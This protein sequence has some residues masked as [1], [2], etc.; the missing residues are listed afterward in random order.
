MHKYNISLS[1][2][3]CFIDIPNPISLFIP[4]N[5]SLTFQSPVYQV[6]N[7]LGVQIL[8]IT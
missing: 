1:T 7:G 4:G 3:Q 6:H 5:A 2:W 8:F